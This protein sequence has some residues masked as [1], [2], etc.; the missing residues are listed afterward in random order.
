MKARG[1]ENKK[2]KD[3]LVN[4]P[5]CYCVSVP[6]VELINI[7]KDIP[8]EVNKEEEQGD[9]NR[10][11]AMLMGSLTHNLETLQK[12]KENLLMAIKLNNALGEEV[13]TLISELCKPS[14][15]D[16][17]KIFIGDLDKVVNLLL[18]WW[19]HLAHMQNLLIGLGED[20]SNEEKSPLN[21]N[22]ARQISGLSAEESS[23][24]FH[25]KGR[26]PGSPSKIHQYNDS[27]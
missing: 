11:K 24:R 6:K 19:R 21:K 5:A 12:E 10:K 16:K 22:L 26:G 15:F 23:L 1:G 27:S 25:S 18:S 14:E 17:Y 9:V 20:A 8:E 3:M 13:E 4:C 2:T 7:V